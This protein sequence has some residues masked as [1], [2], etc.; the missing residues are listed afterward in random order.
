LKEKK[1]SIYE[2]SLI[3]QNKKNEKIKL[4]KEKEKNTFK[5]PNKISDKKEKEE[6][7]ENFINKMDEDSNKI[8]K[9]LD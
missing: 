5:S 6:R 3:Q 2:R 7:I 8:K 4:I 1:K 9:K